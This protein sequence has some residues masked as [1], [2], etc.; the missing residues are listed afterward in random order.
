MSHIFKFDMEFFYDKCN[1][2][3]YFEIT[4]SWIGS[5]TFLNLLVVFPQDILRTTKNMTFQVKLTNL[6]LN[7]NAVCYRGF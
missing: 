3:C 6:N 5:H 4:N 1:Q 2:R 7:L